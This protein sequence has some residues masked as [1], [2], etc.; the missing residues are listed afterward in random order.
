MTPWRIRDR[1]TF[2]SLRRSRW[3]AHRGAVRITYV[4]EPGPSRARVSYAVGRRVGHAVTRNRIRRR[5]RPIMAALPLAPGA[6]LVAAGPEV[7]GADSLTLRRDV[8]AAVAAAV[9]AAR[10][11]EPGR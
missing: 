7:L 10:S 3:R 2:E 5:L 6:Y 8:A 1:A 9:D 11:S 4:P